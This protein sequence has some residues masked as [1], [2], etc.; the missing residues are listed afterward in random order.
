MNRWF[1]TVFLPSLFQKTGY[2]PLFLTRSQTNV[3]CENMERHEARVTAYQGDY[4][5]HTYYTYRWNDRDVRLDFSKL[6]G[7]GQIRFGMNEDDQID[8]LL[9]AMKREQELEE[10]RIANRIRW[11]M[12]GKDGI[13]KR[14]PRYIKD[15]REKIESIEWMLEDSVENGDDKAVIDRYEWQLMKIRNELARYEAVI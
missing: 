11:Y 10:T 5:K 6:N 1:E 14:M 9:D 12:E 4:Y 2:T 13:V 3:C 8:G 7:C 15:L